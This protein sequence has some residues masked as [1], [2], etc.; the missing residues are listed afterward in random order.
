MKIDV[1]NREPEH[2]QTTWDGQTRDRVKQWCT[3][4]IDGLVTSFQHTVNPGEELK[5]GS[6]RLSPA[7]FSVQNGRLQMNR[8][9]LEPMRSN[10]SPAKS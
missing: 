1:L 5:P 10:A 6:Y 4:E 7:S 2:V 9:V 3:I 8:P